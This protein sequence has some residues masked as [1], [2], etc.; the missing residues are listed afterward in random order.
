MFRLASY[1]SPFVCC[2]VPVLAGVV[3][4]DVDGPLLTAAAGVMPRGVVRGVPLYRPVSG[5]G[6]VPH[7]GGLGEV[8]TGGS[9]ALG[10]VGRR[11]CRWLLSPKFQRGTA[12]RR[13]PVLTTVVDGA[14]TSSCRRPSSA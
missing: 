6:G 14:A 7:F 8:P 1:G 2:C 11:S 13:P 9:A 10:G 3:S 12:A 5:A 4:V